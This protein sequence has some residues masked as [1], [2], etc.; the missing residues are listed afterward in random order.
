[1]QCLVNMVDESELPS[2]AEQLL[3]G[4]QRNMWSCVILVEDNVF[5]LD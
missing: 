5:S 1:M 3:S 2:Q 4:H